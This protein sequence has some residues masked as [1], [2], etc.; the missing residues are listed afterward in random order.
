MPSVGPG[1]RR[2][3]HEPCH[4]K[5]ILHVLP[6]D[7]NDSSLRHNH[8]LYSRGSNRS[9]GSASGLAKGT[10]LLGLTTISEKT[11]L[12][13]D[14]FTWGDLLGTPGCPVFAGTARNRS[15]RETAIRQGWRR[16]SL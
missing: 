10:C 4:E 6:P 7:Q 14:I 1:Q 3:H 13:K 2:R 5:R 16:R 12:R 15:S 8:P 9:R 11:T